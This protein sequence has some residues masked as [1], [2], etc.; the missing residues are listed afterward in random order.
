MQDKDN[1]KGS[2][3]SPIQRRDPHTVQGLSDKELE[4][5]G[6]ILGAQGVIVIGFK[7]PVGKDNPM[8]CQFSLSAMQVEEEYMTGALGFV[9]QMLNKNK[10]KVQVK[11]VDVPED[12]IGDEIR[13][14]MFKNGCKTE[15]TR[16]DNIVK[17][18]L[19][20]MKEILEGK[21]QKGA[22][23]IQYE[24]EARV[25]KLIA[26]NTCPICNVKQKGNVMQHIKA[27]AMWERRRNDKV[28]PYTELLSKSME[29]G[30][31]K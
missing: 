23:E 15:Y 6:S 27:K 8:A 16:K 7:T 5:L 9:T 11:E 14:N 30:E 18:G 1:K 3:V 20:A 2:V 10:H 26:Q 17:R 4:R 31:A 28:R 22:T 13:A 24:E 12:P 19:K 25:K 21:H 29:H